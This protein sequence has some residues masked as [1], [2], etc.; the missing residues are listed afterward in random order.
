MFKNLKKFYAENIDMI[1]AGVAALNGND[2][3][4]YI[5]D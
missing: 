4:P 2:I 5:A 1:A 3:Y